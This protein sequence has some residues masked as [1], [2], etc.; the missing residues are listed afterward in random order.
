MH[1]LK[2]R[3][4]HSGQAVSFFLISN[5]SFVYY[6]YSCPLADQIRFRKSKVDFASIWPEVA[7]VS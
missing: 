1:H 5:Q 2:K 7:N 6:I 3:E 4:L